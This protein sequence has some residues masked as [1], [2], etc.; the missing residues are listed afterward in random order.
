LQD[1]ASPPH[2]RND[3]HVLIA[4][5]YE[6]WS[7]N[8]P[9]EILDYAT[10]LPPA[11]DLGVSVTGYEPISQ[12]FDTN[13]YVGLAPSTLT[14]QGLTEYTN[15]N[16][17]SEDTIFTE[18]SDPN[19]RHYFPFPRRADTEEYEQDMGGR[20]RTYFRKIQNG[21]A[22]EHFAVAGRFYR[23]LPSWPEVQI[24]FV[25]FDD[26][27]HQE[28]AQKLIPRG[29]GYSV[30]LLNFFFRGNIG[31]EPDNQSTSGYV[32]VNNTEEVMDGVFELYYDNEQDERI[33]IKSW[34]LNLDPASSGNNKSGNIDFKIPDNAKEPGK[35]MLV[36][37]G[38]LGAEP[39]AVV[40]KIVTAGKFYLY[41][42]CNGYTPTKILTVKLVDS[43]GTE[44]KAYSSSEEP[45]KVGP[46]EGIN[47]PAT[48]YLYYKNTYGELLFTFW[49]PCNADDPD[50]KHGEVTESSCPVGR[51]S[52][53]VEFDVPAGPGDFNIKEVEWKK[54][55]T[56]GS[57]PEQSNVF[58]F[59]GLKVLEKVKVHYK[60][61]YPTWEHGCNPEPETIIVNEKSYP[62]FVS[63]LYP[64]KNCSGD[65]YGDVCMP[66]D[67]QATPTSPVSPDGTCL[68]YDYTR[69]IGTYN[70]IKGTMV[71]LTDADGGDPVFADVEINVDAWVPLF[72]IGCC[73]GGGGP[74]AFQEEYFTIPSWEKYIYHMINTPL[75]RI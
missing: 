70:V 5:G 69:K 24:Y 54:G 1:S 50:V 64:N 36:F 37:R 75:D 9:G 51:D 66:G 45:N 30:G 53:V 23:Y 26:L 31:M 28:Y 20:Y 7:N 17:A 32:I 59:S 40:G 68:L 39:D 6:N 71:I 14:T 34:R 44:H 15:A 63:G 43:D 27:C 25:G 61:W 46:F 4:S 49:T 52:Y 56:V 11:V 21:E 55:P 41:V 33:S 42:T 60:T 18:N 12:F 38:Q 65:Y 29:V 48:P 58:D 13:Q 16:F 22:I 57:V 3:A 62:F 35:Y 74:D 72:G 47:F 10:P 2:T 8:N 67:C 73:D 19:D